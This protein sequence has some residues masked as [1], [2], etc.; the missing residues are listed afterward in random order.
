MKKFL[1][2]VLLILV[3]FVLFNQN[4]VTW[5]KSTFAS[6]QSSTAQQRLEFFEKLSREYYGIPDYG[7]EL[8]MVNGSVAIDRLSSDLTEL[9]IP[10]LEAVTRLKERQT[11]AAIENQSRARAS[12]VKEAATQ[13]KS[14]E[15]E[16]SKS[17]M[18]FLVIGIIVISAII[19][20]LSYLKF[21]S[22]TRRSDLLK[23]S[24]DESIMMDDSIL[25]DFDLAS[26]EEKRPQ[27]NLAFI[28]SVN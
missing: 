24:D 12:F 13:R 4:M 7:R 3:L 10:S 21:R 2:T 18:L 27:P 14:Q 26:F 23:F 25:I 22:R 5:V 28:E 19:S 1:V 6:S 9:I 20:L 11:L 17:S 8:D 16:P 15:V